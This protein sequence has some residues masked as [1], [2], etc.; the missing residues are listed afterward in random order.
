MR[1]GAYIVF[2]IMLVLASCFITG[3]A[4]SPS[5]P[6]P[7]AQATQ[8]T[9]NG[10]Y[11]DV[12]IPA[13]NYSFEEVTSYVYTAPLISNTGLP[14]AHSEVHIQMV[15]GEG[16]DGTGN[17]SSWLFV[18]HYQDHTAYVTYDY[19]G[20]RVTEWSGGYPKEEV[21]IDQVIP[22]KTLFEKNRDK[23]FN[24]PDAIITGSRELALTGSNYTLTIKEKDKTRIL[25]F[26]AKTGALTSS[27][28]R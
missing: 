4:S 9:G 22:P 21:F 6:P 17:A 24:T 16:L 7:Q 10:G 11:Q 12:S 14:L 25:D 18:V 28:E 23:I 3:C 13:Q 26:D 27:Y 19:T 15:Q 1:S 8:G 20:E 2:S 5:N